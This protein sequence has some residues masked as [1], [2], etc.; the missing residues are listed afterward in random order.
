MRF[1]VSSLIIDSHVHIGGPPVQSE[2]DKFVKLMEKSKIDKAIIFRYLYNKPTSAS[3]KFVQSITE[4]YPKQFIG[5]A[6]INPNEKTAAKEVRT[7]INEWNLEGLKLH[8]EMNPSPIS[9]LREVFQEAE[10]LSIPICIHLG[11][12]FA[13][14]DKLSQEFAVPIII[15]HLGTGVYRLEIERLKKAIELAKHENVY[16]ET[17]GN[18]YPFVDYAVNSVSASKIILGSDF[19]H[20]HPLVS[21]RIVQLLELSAHDEELILGLNIKKLLGI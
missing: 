13:C 10:N 12:D 8:L 18:T 9:K 1:E 16:L 6:W 14:I 11:E 17:S 2:P 5:F 4:K 15:A 7:A 3:N 21:V 19:P 20:E